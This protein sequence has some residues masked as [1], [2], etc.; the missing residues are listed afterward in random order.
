MLLELFPKKV[1][2]PRVDKK[3]VKKKDI[4]LKKQTV[5]KLSYIIT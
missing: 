2:V 3:T 5:T 4:T 1:S